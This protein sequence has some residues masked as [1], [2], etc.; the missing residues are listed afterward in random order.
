[1]E[2][3]QIHA[4]PLIAYA[5]ALLPSDEGKVSPKF[6][7]KCFKMPDESLFQSIT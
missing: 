3:Y 7:K 1:M 5:E 4:E 2:E 6:Q